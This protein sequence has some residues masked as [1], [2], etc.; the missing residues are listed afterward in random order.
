ML[1]LQQYIDKAS[2]CAG[3]LAY[4][5]VVCEQNGLE[6]KKKA[7]HSR[8]MLLI[9]NALQCVADGGTCLTDEQTQKLKERVNELCGCCNGGLTDIE[10]TQPDYLTDD[11]L[12]ILTDDNYSV[13][14]RLTDT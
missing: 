9:K 5:A 2:C 11:S 12:V 14:S 7:A 6:Y 1:T 13:N 8:I 10:G 4:E 3:Q